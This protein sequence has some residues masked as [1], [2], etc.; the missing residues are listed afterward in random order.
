MLE[1]LREQARGDG[2]LMDPILECVRTY[3]TL[4]EICISGEGA[5]AYYGERARD[6]EKQMLIKARLSAG[7][8]EPAASDL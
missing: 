7:E 2:N 3:G 1:A 5:R 8:P 6:W 4:G